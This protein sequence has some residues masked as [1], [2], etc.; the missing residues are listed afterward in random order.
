MFDV[1]LLLYNTTLNINITRCTLNKRHF[2]GG[3][4]DIY[5][6][7]AICADHIIIYRYLLVESIIL[8][9]IVVYGCILLCIIAIT[10][11]CNAHFVTNILLV[12]LKRFWPYSKVSNRQHKSIWVQWVMFRR[13]FISIQVLAAVLPPI[14]YYG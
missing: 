8:V 7:N 9:Y 12:K 1:V 2:D 6:S 11:R 4:S 10:Y 5:P 3:A 14:S 13:Y